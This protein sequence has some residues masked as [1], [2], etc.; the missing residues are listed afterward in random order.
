MT[1]HME[2]VM[3]YYYHMFK[4]LMHKL[5]LNRLKKVASI[6]GVDVSDMTDEEG[7]SACIDAIKELSKSIGI[8]AGFIRVRC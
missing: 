8:P 5:Q 6:M 3:Q 2:F 4:N 1:Y 7:A